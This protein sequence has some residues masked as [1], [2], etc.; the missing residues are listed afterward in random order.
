MEEGSTVTIVVRPT[1]LIR[2]FGKFSKFLLA[3]VVACSVRDEE[4]GGYTKIHCCTF[5]VLRESNQLTAVTPEFKVRVRGVIT[6]QTVRLDGAEQKSQQRPRKD[7]TSVVRDNA[8]VIQVSAVLSVDAVTETPLKVAAVV[9]ALPPQ[10]QRVARLRGFKERVPAFI[11]HVWHI[12]HILE[13]IDSKDRVVQQQFAWG[14]LPHIVHTYL[15]KWYTSRS[16]LQCTQLELDLL[17]DAHTSVSSTSPGAL[18]ADLN[19]QWVCYRGVRGPLFTHTDSVWFPFNKYRHF[20]TKTGSTVFKCEEDGIPESVAHMVLPVRDTH[21]QFAR[22]AAL[23]A[24]LASVC[25][26]IPLTLVHVAGGSYGN[27]VAALLREADKRE[28]CAVAPHVGWAYHLTTPSFPVVDAHNVIHNLEVPIRCPVP[29]L[30]IVAAEGWS[31][32]ELANVIRR[33]EPEEMWLVGYPYPSGKVGAHPWCRGSPFRDM[34]A[35]FPQHR[36]NHRVSFAAGV[37]TDSDTYALH[38]YAPTLEARDDVIVMTPQAS[39]DADVTLYGVGAIGD[40]PLNVRCKQVGSWMAFPDVGEVRKVVARGYMHRATAVDEP[41]SR[42]HVQWVA[43]P[44]FT[45]DWYVWVDLA[46]VH[47]GVDHRYCCNSDSPHVASL[48]VHSSAET[49]DT[50]AA[51]WV[52]NVCAPG[53]IPRV[54]LLLGETSHAGH[55]QAAARVARDQLVL[56]GD[57]PAALKR[58]RPGVFTNLR[59]TIAAF[60]QQQQALSEIPRDIPVLSDAAMIGNEHVTVVGWTG[61]DVPML[62]QHVSTERVCIAALRATNPE[63][64]ASKQPVDGV[65]AFAGLADVRENSDGIDA[66]DVPDTS[67]PH[68]FEPCAPAE[69]GNLLQF[70]LTKHLHYR[71]RAFATFDSAN[72]AVKQTFPP[73]DQLEWVKR[74][75]RQALLKLRTNVGVDAV[76]P[77]TYEWAALF[78][79]LVAT[80]GTAAASWVLE[81]ERRLMEYREHPDVETHM[82]RVVAFTKTLVPFHPPSTP[83]TNPFVNNVVEVHNVLTGCFA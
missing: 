69:L 48:D 56:V 58:K 34:F 16:L 12:C 36:H 35:A 39:S 64:A 42:Q 32:W 62:D 6:K 78:I 14:F 8:P 2:Q 27:Y 37:L 15:S 68:V 79:L 31:Y 25:V 61:R 82:E 11:E 40:I 5:V 9:P 20:G 3:R 52:G 60:A 24:Y 10:E 7:N 72:D 23:E 30:V 80:H 73:F 49:V 45:E 74:P 33:T 13:V 26:R 63:L 51:G 55:I 46:P 70:E 41:V 50:H 18:C 21:F 44:V 81:S 66:M 83:S 43:T 77:Y 17:L 59:A 28:W 67:A 47:S 71:L 22:D 65:L 53:S 54:Q 76:N 29:V 38:A 1:R 19:D 57:V 4:T 75:P